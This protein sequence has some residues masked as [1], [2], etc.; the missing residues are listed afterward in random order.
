MDLENDLNSVDLTKFLGLDDNLIN[1]EHKANT[2]YATGVV[3][4]QRSPFYRETANVLG[5][6]IRPWN[7][8]QQQ[9]IGKRPDIG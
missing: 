2:Q 8:L 3:N 4:E 9:S 5:E 1:S 6:W 7:F